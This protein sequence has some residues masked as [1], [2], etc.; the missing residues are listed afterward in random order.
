MI[1]IYGQSITFAQLTLGCDCSK[2]WSSDKLGQLRRNTAQAGRVRRVPGE[3]L[4]LVSH[5]MS[6]LGDW[7]SHSV[8]M[9]SVSLQKL[10]FNTERL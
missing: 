9:C 2:Y 4:V 6:F 8:L 1:S 3:A 5:E 7:V 10:I